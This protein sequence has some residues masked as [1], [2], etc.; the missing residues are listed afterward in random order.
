MKINFFENSATILKMVVF[1]LMILALIA[2][3]AACGV[4]KGNDIESDNIM[5]LYVIGGTILTE[6]W[7]LF[8]FVVADMAEDISYIAR[9]TERVEEK[10]HITEKTYICPNCKGVLKPN[11]IPKYYPTGVCPHCNQQFS[12]DNILIR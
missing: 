8:M 9:Y 4:I 2:C 7:F 5:I 1:V 10:S 12:K 3:I 6:A 11:D